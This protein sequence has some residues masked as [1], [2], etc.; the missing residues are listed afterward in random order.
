MNIFKKLIKEV[1]ELDA[2][3]TEYKT[4][5]FRKPTPAPPSNPNF[6]YQP[7]SKS[8]EKPTPPKTGS[9]VQ[10]K[11]MNC[12]YET[13]CGWCTKWDKKCD[14]KMPERG[15]RAKANIIDETS[16]PCDECDKVGWDMPECKECNAADGFKYFE[17]KNTK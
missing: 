12:T 15:L 10:S 8:P 14:N 13:P 3:L 1:K 5:E 7:I 6:G 16:S 9:K 17:R 4:P 2:A 11:E